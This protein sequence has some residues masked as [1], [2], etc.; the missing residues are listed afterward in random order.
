MDNNYTV[1]V[2]TILLDVGYTKIQKVELHRRAKN[3]NALYFVLV[4]GFPLHIGKRKHAIAM[5]NKYTKA[6]KTF[7]S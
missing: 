4:N 2:P 5:Y 1:F 3:Q 6:L 7:S